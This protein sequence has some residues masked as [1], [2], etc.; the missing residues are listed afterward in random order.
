MKNRFYLP[1]NNTRVKN[2]L[3][4]FLIIF[5]HLVSFSQS[6]SSVIPNEGEQGESLEIT[7]TGENTTW[8]QSSNTLSFKQASNTIYPYSQSTNSDTEIVGSFSFNYLHETGFYDVSVEENGSGDEVVLVNGFQLNEGSLPE[9]ISVDP[10]QGQQVTALTVTITGDGTDFTQGSPVIF[11]QASNIPIFP[12]SQNVL[13]ATQLECDFL[14]N[15]DHPIGFYDVQ[16]FAVPVVLENGFEVTAATI[17]PELNGIDPDT[18]EQGETVR[19][20]ISGTDTHFNH[21]QVTNEVYLTAPGNYAYGINLE[22]IDAT[23]LEADF[24]F[25]YYHTPGSYGLKVYNQLDGLMTLENV[26]TLEAGPDAPAISSVEPDSAMQTEEVWI[27]ITGENV[28]F[29]QGSVTFYLYQSSGTII[30]PNEQNVINDT[31][32]EGDF[33][34]NPDQNTGYYDVKI[35]NPS[36]YLENGFYLLPPEEYPGEPSNEPTS[37]SQGEP[38]ILTVTVENAHF[39][40]PDLETTCS[41]LLSRDEGIIADNVVVIDSNVIE[42]EFNFTE[43]DTPGLYDLKVFNELDGTMWVDD[44]FT[45]EGDTTSV[46]LVDVSPDNAD[47]GESLWITITGHNSQFTTGSATIK[48][49]QG[50]S[51]FIYPTD[52]EV[53]NDTQIGGDFTFNQEDPVG[54]YDVF[55]YD[56]GGTWSLDLTNGFYLD[57]YVSIGE[58]EETG[59]ARV[60]PNP[61]KDVLTVERITGENNTITFDILNLAGEIVFSDLLSANQNSQMVNISEFESGVYMFRLR[62]GSKV[63]VEKFVIR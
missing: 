46:M 55:V 15:P 44:A 1:F 25:E 61:A 12:V 34:F 30:Y 9:I 59:I 32:I 16:L 11:F 60:Y 31:V 62:S 58:I 38:L 28:D 63:K 24:T 45:L 47:Q 27:T 41:L 50:S 14:L 7:V 39:D 3:L 23:T 56:F 22:A 29:N 51:T 8:A 18:A 54:Y 19:L 17:F 20:T 48:F 21:P 49:V 2:I 33:F 52:A 35:Y 6:I 43:N 40:H 26:F 42:A 13:S 37:G 53:Y 57:K 36:L 5:T 10:N 4:L